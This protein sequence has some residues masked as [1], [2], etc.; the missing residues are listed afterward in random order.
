MPVTKKHT[1]TS[2]KRKKRV[3]PVIV[4]TNTFIPAAENPFPEKLKKAKEILNKTKFL[5]R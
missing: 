5:D 1:G 2:A 4:V 3:P